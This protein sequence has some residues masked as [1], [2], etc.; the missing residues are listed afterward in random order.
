MLRF[1]SIKILFL[2]SAIWGA[3]IFWVAPHPPMVDLAQH[4]GQI[5]LL[6]DLALGQSQW[7]DLV[8]VNLFTP[9]L[10]GYGL[11]LPFTFLFSVA[12]S[13][14]IVLSIAFICFVTAA[15]VLRKKYGGDERLDWL[16]LLGFFGFAYNWGLYTFLVS[17]PIAL[18]LILY[19]SVYASDPTLKKGFAVFLIGFFLLASHGLSFVFACGVGGIIYLINAKSFR[20]FLSNL[21]PFLG[22]AIACGLYFFGSRMTEAELAAPYGAHVSWALGTHRVHETVLHAFGISPKPVFMF[23]AAVLLL[24]PW[25]L[26]LNIQWQNKTSFVMLIFVVLISL[27]VPNFALKTALLYQRF[28]VF[29]LPAYALAFAR[30]SSNYEGN[31]NGPAWNKVSRFIVMPL[32][33]LACWAVLG[34]YTMDAHRFAEESKDIDSMIKRIEPGSRALALIF[35][36][37]SDAIKNPTIYSN[38]ASWYQAERKGF[39]DFNFAWFPPQIVRFRPSHASPVD[40][41]FVLTEFD[42]KRYNA[43]Q[44]KYFIIRQSATVK[45]DFFEGAACKPV[46]I[47]SMNKW[48]IY[49]QSSC[50]R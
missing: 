36:P 37:E 18:L 43:D 27:F 50:T 34:S 5:S 16:F 15:I 14:K 23:A 49:E 30:T 1:S 40:I 28:A 48:R 24:A 12:T 25:M 10:L 8:R 6:H 31:I 26:R 13:L 20:T 29:F 44:Y 47:E 45:D 4:A 22:L 2:I 7:S 21:W 38:Y 42:W 41:N 46:L 17:A 19:S 9:Y 39:V 3:A 32:V 33:I 35:S 11:A